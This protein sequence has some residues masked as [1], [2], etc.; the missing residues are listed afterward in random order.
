MNSGHQIKELIGCCDFYPRSNSAI[1]NRCTHKKAAP[2]FR[3]AAF[4]ILTVPEPVEG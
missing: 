3:K 2:H 1:E 4:G